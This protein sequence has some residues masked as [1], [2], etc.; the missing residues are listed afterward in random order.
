M[1]TWIPPAFKLMES[2]HSAPTH[3][4]PTTEIVTGLRTLRRS[5][6]VH[7]SFNSFVTRCD[8]TA[9][10][11]QPLGKLGVRSTLCDLSRRAPVDGLVTV[12]VNVLEN[13]QQPSNSQDYSSPSYYRGHD[14]EHRNRPS[15]IGSMEMLIEWT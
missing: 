5:L 2:K 11:R 14:I 6:T 8:N 12:G 13:T 3:V 9:F 1:W 7:V 15:P 4:G 10:V